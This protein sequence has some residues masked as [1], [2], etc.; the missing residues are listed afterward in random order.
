[1]SS[2]LPLQRSDILNRLK[3]VV[4]GKVP[5]DMARF[6]PEARLSDIGLDSFSLIELVFL[7][8]EEF[9]IRIPVEGLTVNTV[10][11]VLDVISQ[12]IRTPNLC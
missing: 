7:A 11:D 4:S 6:S 2:P 10:G 5:V 1:M 8:E 9:G 3:E 12:R